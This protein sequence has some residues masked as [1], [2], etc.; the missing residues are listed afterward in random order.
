M[1]RIEGELPP[2]EPTEGVQ[3]AAAGTP[4]EGID[5]V[6]DSAGTARRTI[7]PGSGG[8]PVGVLRAALARALPPG[9]KLLLEGVR[10]LALA[11][12]QGDHEAIE[13]EAAA[14]AAL[15]P[16]RSRQ[17]VG[18]GAL[19]WEGAATRQVEGAL[20]TAQVGAAGMAGVRAEAAGASHLGVDGLAAAGHAETKAGFE[21]AVA[22]RLRSALLDADA[23][24][25][26]EALLYG[27]AEG[28][29]TANWRE[30]MRARGCAEIGARAQLTYDAA[31]QTAGCTIAGQ[32]VDLNGEVH[33]N[34]ELSAR[35][36]VDADI[37]ATIRPPR[38]L[39][40]AKAEA[41]AGAKAGVD[42]SIGLG[43]FITVTGTAEAW[44][45]VGAE[46]GIICGYDDGKLRLGF[47]AGAAAELGAGAGLAVEIDIGALAG[48]LVAGDVDPADVA[49][50]MLLL[51]PLA[52]QPDGVREPVQQA[53]EELEQAMEQLEQQQ[54]VEDEHQR[55]EREHAAET[56]G[57]LLGRMR[58][59]ER[60]GAPAAGLADRLARELLASAAGPLGAAIAAQVGGDDGPG[61]TGGGTAATAGGLAALLA[62]DPALTPAWTALG[63]VLSASG[64]AGAARAVLEHAVSRAAAPVAALDALAGACLKLGDLGAGLA[65]LE[66]QA[67]ASAAAQAVA[68]LLAMSALAQWVGDLEGAESAA[69]RALGVQPESAAAQHYLA[70]VYDAAGLEG[71]AAQRYRR[72]IATDQGAWRP[73]N[74]LGYLLASHREEDAS[75]GEGLALLRDAAHLAPEGE[76][77]PRFNLAL[78]LLGQGDPA[79]AGELLQALAEEFPEDHPLRPDIVRALAACGH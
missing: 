78:V 55:A 25:G 7:R 1:S 12:E 42:A 21:G 26:A 65:A 56:I 23:R 38:M 53:L 64:S 66:Q 67:G 43:D 63:D 61:F 77:R 58:E 16:S 4:G 70:C 33:A 17:G 5:E 34:A 18:E 13:R 48:A 28:Q 50:L 20:G 59:P 79:G 69:L 29:V 40:E 10:A 22:G 9:L 31:F 32:R 30:G 57:A 8:I 19:G 41:F 2:V 6:A 75:V 14:L 36:G 11:L 44:A 49:D 72:A 51:E 35:A 74:D 60:T 62:N 45:G 76:P 54:R 52:S 3:G 73:R 39:C 37:A 27:E 15:A 71:L 46:A 68:P 47:S 24:L